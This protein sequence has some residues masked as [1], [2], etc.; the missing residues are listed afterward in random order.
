MQP[1]G[2]SPAELILAAYSVWGKDCP[3]QIEGDFAFV[4]WDSN[5]QTVLCGRDFA[6]RRPLFYAD[7]AGGLVVASTVE[8]V[9]A[10]PSCPHDINI[11][12]VGS[13]AA[14]MLWSV[15]SDTCYQAIMPVPMASAML[16]Q[17]DRSPQV[18]RYWE[19]PAVGTSRL[20]FVDAADELRNLLEAA[21]IERMAPSGPT[22]VWMSG[23]WDSTAVF[24]CGMSAMKN[25]RSEQR[26]LPVSISYPPGDPGHEDEFI[27]AVAK[28]WDMPIHWLDI[29]D[30]PL[31]ED[32]EGR[33][34]RRDE[35]VA[36][37]YE[38]WTRGLARGTR[39]VGARVVLDGNGGDQLFQ[40]T[41]IFLAD[42]LRSGRLVQLLGELRTK[43]GRGALHLAEVMI[44]P[45]LPPVM[46]RMI[47]ALRGRPVPGHYLRR[48]VPRWLNEA[49][50]GQAGLVERERACLPSRGATDRAAE[51]LQWFVTSPGPGYMAGTMAPVLAQEGVEARSPLLDRRVVEF[52]MTR[53]RTER[54]KLRETKRLLREALRG[55]LPAEVLAPR[56][57]RTGVT[58][59]YSR[60]AMHR[61]YPQ[62]FGRLLQDP[63]LLAELGMVDPRRLRE[64]VDRVQRQGG[65]FERVGLFHTLQAELWLRTHSRSKDYSQSLETATV[66]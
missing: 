14:G 55:L 1:T 3:A 41:D 36:A 24:G 32:V 2:N 18:W 60:Q 6:G 26:L 35:P 37:L 44:L 23:G 57:Y 20:G 53:P 30:I 48:P 66:A 33:A 21:V 47:G 34:S 50:V 46:L 9:L 25:D 54:A 56:P 64:A 15:G 19:P 22:S 52:A 11:A 49:F 10:H 58:V 8:A 27:T 31:F 5:T 40:G 28:Q 63:L 13:A 29:A 45:S 39:Q 7:I 62:A 42:L 4:L 12:V 61:F 38:N 59:G 16:W 17:P 65:E 43:W 51:E